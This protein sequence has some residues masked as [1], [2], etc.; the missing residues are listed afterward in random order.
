MK[1]EFLVADEADEIVCGSCRSVALHGHT[2]T[3]V[4]LV[5]DVSCLLLRT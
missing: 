5:R 4:G 1:K 3:T 2:G